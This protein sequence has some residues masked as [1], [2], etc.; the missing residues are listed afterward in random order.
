[1]LGFKRWNLLVYVACHFAQGVLHLAFGLACGCW[2]Q[3]WMRL[4]TTKKRHWLKLG[5]GTEGGAAAEL[6]K[7][8]GRREGTIP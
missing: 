6:K 8:R 7:A 5:G 1:M 3:L 2:M 4:D